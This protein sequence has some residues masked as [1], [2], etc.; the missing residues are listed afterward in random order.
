MM[1][2]DSSCNFDATSSFLALLVNKSYRE[3]LKRAKVKTSFQPRSKK[4]QNNFSSRKFCQI[5][6]L[7]DLKSFVGQ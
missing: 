4:V 5:T 7:K 6:H 1:G 3:K 2:F